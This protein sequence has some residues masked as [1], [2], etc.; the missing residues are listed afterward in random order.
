MLTKRLFFTKIAVAVI[1]MIL[2]FIV[3]SQLNLLI[4]LSFNH[5]MI[6][7][8]VTSLLFAFA[9]TSYSYL[10]YPCVKVCISRHTKTTPL[11]DEI[12]STIVQLPFFINVF[13]RSSSYIIR[14]H[15]QWEHSL[16]G[17]GPPSPFICGC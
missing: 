15:R 2:F 16:L 3:F 1:C 7:A 8:A 13:Q 6:S 5:Y 11:P 4:T 17:R 9:F 10:L 14:T 12:G